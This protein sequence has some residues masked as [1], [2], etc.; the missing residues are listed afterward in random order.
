MAYSFT[1]KNISE[2]IIRQHKKGVRVFG[3]FERRGSRS[4]YSEYIK[5]KIEGLK[6]RLDRNRYAMHHKT[7]IIDKKRLITG[8]YNFSKS[9]N[10]KNDENILIIY[11]KEVAS[12][13]LEEFEY[14]WKNYSS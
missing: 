4:R 13:Y 2:A 12:K 3:L 9:A 1:S 10:S 5:M 14:I 11:D 6:V 7:I 8:S